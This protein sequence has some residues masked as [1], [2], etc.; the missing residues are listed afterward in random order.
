[1]KKIGLVILG[2]G[3]LLIGIFSFDKEE[4][5]VLVEEK[6]NNQNTSLV[7]MLEDKKGTY[8]ISENIPSGYS[9]NT[10]KNVVIIQFQHGKIIN[11][12]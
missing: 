4:N 10:S 7:F 3:V 5:R 12:I 8:N 11:Y 9:L 1:M 2:M 6:L